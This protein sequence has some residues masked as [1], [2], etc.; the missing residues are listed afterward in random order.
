MDFF[1]GSITGK[2]VLPKR[3]LGQGLFQFFEMKKTSIVEPLPKTKFLV[4]KSRSP[5]YEHSS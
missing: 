2:E 3:I 1:G 4:L 5:R